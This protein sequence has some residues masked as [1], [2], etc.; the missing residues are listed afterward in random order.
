LALR[1]QRAPQPGD[2]AKPPAPSR[3]LALIFAFLEPNYSM[4]STAYMLYV[5][6]WKSGFL[7]LRA[8]VIGKFE[9]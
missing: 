3:H 1:S 2:P 6:C 8:K 9:R 4:N 5:W 7:Q